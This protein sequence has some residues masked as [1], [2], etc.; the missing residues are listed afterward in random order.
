[1][2]ALFDP[3]VAAGIAFCLGMA[4]LE[5]LRPAGYEAEGPE[6]KMVFRL[7][8]IPVC[9]AVLILVAYGV[10]DHL[11]LLWRLRP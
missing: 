11:Y 10:A 7:L 5:F 8:L 1:M 3:L 2:A 6:T 4:A 9:I